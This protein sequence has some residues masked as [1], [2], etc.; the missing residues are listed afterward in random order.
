MI[1]I[2][3]DTTSVIEPKEAEQLDITMIPQIIVIGEKSYRDD[4]EITTE[5]FLNKLKNSPI[6]PKTAAPPPALYAPIYEEVAVN[7][8][9]AIVICPSADVSGTVR[10]ASIAA[11]DYPGADIHVFDSRTIGPAL[12]TMVYKAKEWADTGMS[13]DEII[14]KLEAA[15]RSN[16]IYFYVDTL[17]YLHKGGRIGGAQALFG[18]I[19]QVKPILAFVDG[20]VVPYETQRT[21]KRALARIIELVKAECPNSPKAHAAI[22]QADAMADAEQLKSEL[23]TSMDA[24]LIELKK[25][26]PAIIVHAGPGVLAVSFFTNFPE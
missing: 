21:K 23:S 9:T 13:A 12:G 3:A 19:L 15:K 22:F 4:N 16:K 5:E 25:I 24:N 20:K 7:K 18:S 11:Q 6:L 17:E 10:S 26:P 8:D 14:H 2:I 1:K